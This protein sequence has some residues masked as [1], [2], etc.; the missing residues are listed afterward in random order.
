MRK[1]GNP[2]KPANP[3]AGFG[4]KE[5]LS[6]SL[7]DENVPA[8]DDLFHTNGHSGN[9]LFATDNIEGNYRLFSPDAKTDFRRFFAKSPV[10]QL[11]TDYSGAILKINDAARE[12]FGIPSKFPA[13]DLLANYLPA[14]DRCAFLLFLTHL[15]N[16]PSPVE[17]NGTTEKTRKLIRIKGQPEEKNRC[18]YLT[19]VDIT[20]E[21]KNRKQFKHR[22]D[23]LEK[24]RHFYQLAI[25]RSD[26]GLWKATVARDTPM[27]TLRF[28]FSDKSGDLFGFVTFADIPFSGFMN[29]IH[30]ESAEK[31]RTALNSAINGKTG[32]DIEIR[33]NKPNGDFAWINWKCCLIEED[34]TGKIRL[35]GIAADITSY[36]TTEKALAIA[37]N[38][39]E[40]N[41][42]GIFIADQDRR[43][44]VVNRQF[45]RMTGLTQEKIMG[46]KPWYLQA[47]IADS[48]CYSQLCDV[49]ACTDHEEMAAFEK[50]RQEKIEPTHLT[51][52][53]V[54]DMDDRIISYI[55]T[56]LDISQNEFLEDHTRYMIEHDFLTGLPNRILLLDRL[57]QTLI[58]AERN[59]RRAAVMFLDLDRFKHINDTLGH[60]MGDRLLQQVA[61]RLTKCVRKNDT[62]SRQ[63]GD[64]F[65]IL[66][67]DIGN[68]DDVALV[69]NNIMHALSQ[70]YQIEN[71]EMS[72]TPSIGIALYPE[73][74]KDIDTLLKN[75]DTA[76][77]HAKEG[78]RNAYQFFNAQMNLHLVERTRLE[79]DL[80]AALQN[81]GF[82]LEYQPIVDTQSG[83]MTGVEAF[84]RWNHPEFG[85][86]TPPRFLGVAEDTGLIG[87]IGEWVIRTACKQAGE[88]RDQGF[89]KTVSI[90]LSSIQ[91]KQKNLLSTIRNALKENG[92]APDFLELQI[93]EGSIMENVKTVSDLLHE[94]RAMGIRIVLDNFGNG[95]SS[96]SHLK[97]API[98]KIKID[99]VF[100]H[101][102]GTGS[103]DAD[104][105]GAIVAMA[106]NLRLKVSAGGVETDLQ[107][108][109]LKEI[110]CDEYQGYLVSPSLSAG[111]ISPFLEAS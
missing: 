21:A 98:G 47:D 86:L 22:I 6:F 35:E 10:A 83:H 80:K 110:G 11:V 69:A 105:A 32:F 13:K 54:R 77:Y 3:A 25:E 9:D 1:D 101:A 44:T 82:F 14:K 36:K 30:P 64:E 8:N 103:E 55:G 45:S 94:L 76:M 95:C 107:A 57:G 50:N 92:L 48:T 65:V 4:Q 7:K 29:T 97:K 37:S 81:G 39:F 91:L 2:E 58:A 23:Q 102:L 27:D 31:I 5:S 20:T 33:V 108:L 100:I 49:I 90:N 79:N 104:V 84:L 88:W 106:K 24:E 74:G 75:A 51:V 78:G 70:N 111:E 109:R 85:I 53:I 40:N 43:I 87:P 72:I 66:L 19:A 26:I 38:L 52:K 42:D 17:W 96:I 93:T 60:A 34:D 73:D 46:N 56:L 16:R 89:P 68:A 67:N 62:V 63:G 12:L 28:H 61:F 41:R 15:E 59:R 99:P 18:L 71:Y